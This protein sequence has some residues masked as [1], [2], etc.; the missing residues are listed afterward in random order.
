MKD[1][2]KGISL[3]K[4]IAKKTMSIVFQNIIFSISIKFAILLLTAFGITNMWLAVFGDVG[5]AVLAILNAM[6]VNLK[7]K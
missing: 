3:A 4:K 5:V 6:R 2:L 1:D 7:Q